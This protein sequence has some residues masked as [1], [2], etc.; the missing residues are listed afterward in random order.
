MLNCQQCAAILLGQ[1][2]HHT[3]LARLPVTMPG[4]GHTFVFFQGAKNAAGVIALI[5]PGIKTAFRRRINLNRIRQPGFQ[6][7]LVG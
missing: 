1:C 4:E 5:P 2:H 3:S 6:H 7:G